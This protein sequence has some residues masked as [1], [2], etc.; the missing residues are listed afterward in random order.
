MTL[1]LALLHL[2]KVGVQSLREVILKL[3]E[4]CAFTEDQHLNK[5]MKSRSEDGMD[6]G[7]LLGSFLNFMLCRKTPVSP[8]IAQPLGQEGNP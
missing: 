2:W 1:H 8:N 4:L 5:N 6:N 7:I 3:L